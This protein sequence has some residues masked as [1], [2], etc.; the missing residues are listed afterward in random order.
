MLL[1]SVFAEI[2]VVVGWMSRIY[3]FLLFSTSRATALRPLELI[4]C[5]H[6]PSLCRRALLLSDLDRKAMSVYFL[7]NGG[8]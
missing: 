1:K 3:L 4:G 6:T 5:I 7:K 8:N 2:V